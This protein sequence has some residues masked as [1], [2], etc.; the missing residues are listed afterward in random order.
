M[1]RGHRVVV[2]AGARDGSVIADADFAAQGAAIAADADAVFGESHLTVKVKEPSA[3]KS[4]ACG[5][6]RSSSRT[7]T[8]R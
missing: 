2:Q 5:P 6:G 3:R 1:A 8:S 7:S 4:D